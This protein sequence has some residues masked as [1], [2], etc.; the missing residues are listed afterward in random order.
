MNKKNNIA[1][2]CQGKN[3]EAPPFQHFTCEAFSLLGEALNA[4]KYAMEHDLN[5]ETGEKKNWS[6]ELYQELRSVYE[7][8]DQEKDHR[9]GRDRFAE[10]LAEIRELKN[11]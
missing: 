1:K 8:F 10:F 5:V 9:E 11:M 7:Y 4:L 3:C 2:S 6:D